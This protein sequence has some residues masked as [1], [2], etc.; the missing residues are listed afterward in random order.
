MLWMFSALLTLILE[1]LWGFEIADGS[2]YFAFVVL[3]F[4]ILPVVFTQLVANQYRNSGNNTAYRALHTLKIIS[5]VAPILLLIGIL[6]Y[7]VLMTEIL[8]VTLTF[9]SMVLPVL[10]ILADVFAISFFDFDA[11]NNSK[12]TVSAHKE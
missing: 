10:I 6:L 8:S 12:K 4:F 2:K 11:D 3:N 5:L 7:E 9:A 1:L